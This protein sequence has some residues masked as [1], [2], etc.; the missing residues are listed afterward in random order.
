MIYTISFSCIA[1]VQRLDFGGHQWCAIGLFDGASEF[2]PEGNLRK[3]RVADMPAEVVAAVNRNF[4]AVFALSLDRREE[5][6]RN[7]QP[8]TIEVAG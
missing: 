3:N 6:I 4:V 2:Y 5:F 7:F 1:S 8:Q